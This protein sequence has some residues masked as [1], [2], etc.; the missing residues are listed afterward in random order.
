MEKQRI[1]WS[2]IPG[3][4]VSVV[5]VRCQSPRE[6]WSAAGLSED[7]EEQVLTPGKECLSYRTDALG[8]RSEGKQTKSKSFLL[9]PELSP[10]LAQS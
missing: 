8:S 2:F 10:E 5:S 3:H 9:S 4:G 6:S 1:W 7:P